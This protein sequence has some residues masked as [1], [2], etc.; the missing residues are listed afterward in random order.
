[1]RP[2]RTIESQSVL[3]LPGGNEDSDLWFDVKEAEGGSMVICSTWEP[4]KAERAAIAAGEN[5]ELI[6]WG[7]SHP[8]V[9]IRTTDVQL[10]K[11]PAPPEPG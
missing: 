6:V 2:R 3:R 9:S 5:V 1:M 10:G 11:A 4:S 8:P 7:T